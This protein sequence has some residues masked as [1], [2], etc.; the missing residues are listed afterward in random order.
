MMARSYGFGETPGTMRV[1]NRFFAA[2]GEAAD[3]YLAY[4]DGH[5]DPVGWSYTLFHPDGRVMLLGG[6]ATVEEFRHR[7]LYTAMVSAQLREGAA[8]GCPAAVVPAVNTSS[9]PACGRLGF[10]AVCELTLYVYV[11]TA[12]RTDTP[13]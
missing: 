2:L 13:S 6:S 9:A 11:P 4:A 3:V 7:G 12:L 8:R 1:F 5:P 10:L